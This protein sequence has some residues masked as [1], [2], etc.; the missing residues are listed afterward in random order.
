MFL[1]H[2]QMVKGTSLKNT[3]KLKIEYKC[4][5]SSLKKISNFDDLKY[6]YIY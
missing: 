1:K 3:I 4:A 6:I 2:V 5:K